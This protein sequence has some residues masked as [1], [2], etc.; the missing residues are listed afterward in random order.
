V[1]LLQTAHSRVVAPRR[2]Q[3][4]ATIVA[5]LIPPESRV[6]DLGAGTG[7]VAQ[8]V[9]QLRPDIKLTALEV[10]ARPDAVISE[11]EYDGRTIPFADGAFAC[12][13][14]VDVVHHAFE[15]VRLLSEARRVSSQRVV[16]KDH[17][18]DALGSRVILS[19]MD[20]VSNARNGISMPYTYW[21]RAEWREMFAQAG[22]EEESWS[23]HLRLYPPPATFLF[24]ASLQFIASLNVSA[25]TSKKTPSP[26]T[27]V[28]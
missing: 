14:L 25:E 19:F 5:P 16:I 6:L 10:K 28:P 2:V 4:I 26:S 8:A 1:S 23:G 18:A 15:P 13:M 24:D 21:T 12:V 3:R 11:I 7:A 17:R 27:F 22:L 20:W 9:I